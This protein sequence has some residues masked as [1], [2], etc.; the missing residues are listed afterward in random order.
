MKKIAILTACFGVLG[1]V[2]PDTVQAGGFYDITLIHEERPEANEYATVEHGYIECDDDHGNAGD[3]VVI[4]SV[5]GDQVS[6]KKCIIEWNGDYWDDVPVTMCP[7]SSCDEET[8][9]LGNYVEFCPRGV[10]YKRIGSYLLV[11][12][13]GGCWL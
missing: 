7:S 13:E 9:K 3:G 11:E 2:M 1:L 12:H 10:D 4:Y 8:V 6:A 5:R